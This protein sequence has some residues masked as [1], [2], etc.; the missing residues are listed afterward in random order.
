M[1][2]YFNSISLLVG[3]VGLAISA[4]M[5][6]LYF[7]DRF[8][9]TS[10]LKFKTI[11]KGCKNLLNQFE[12][13]SYRPD[14]IIGIH[15]IG[16]G[17]GAIVA[18]ILA[19]ELDLPLYIFNVDIKKQNEEDEY[20][21]I[22]SNAINNMTNQKILLVD[23]ICNTGRTLNLVKN[24]VNTNRNDLNIAVIIAPPKHIVS[25]VE[26]DYFVFRSDTGHIYSRDWM[27]TKN[28]K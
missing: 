10:S 23:D 15:T 12:N 4:I 5:A 22:T 6:Y 14:V 2:D 28:K 26:L 19:V 27:I 24:K 8:P 3:I 25:Q 16:I 21:K 7:K 1:E 20:S 9:Q 18:E 17:G 11:V 13:N